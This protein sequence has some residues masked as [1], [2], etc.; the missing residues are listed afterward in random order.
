VWFWP[1]AILVLCV[2]AAWRLQ[3]SRIDALVA[4]I[5]AGLTLFGIILGAV[6]RN[7]HGRPGIS[8]VGVVELAFITV[9]IVWTAWRVLRGRAGA[10]TFFI[11]AV[12]GL[13]EAISLIPTLFNGYVLLAV[14]PFLGRLATIICLGGPIALVW[15]AARI[16]RR[17]HDDEPTEFADDEVASVAAP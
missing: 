6:G 12:V 17:E 3:D 16:F 14:P 13:W 5:V 11:V 4:R 8:G 1:I 9:L 10:L 2:L 15:P 7:L